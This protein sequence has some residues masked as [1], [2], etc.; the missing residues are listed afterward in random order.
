MHTQR[1]ARNG[2]LRRSVTFVEIDGQHGE[3]LRVRVKV[4]RGTADRL[5]QEAVRSNEHPM[6]YLCDLFDEALEDHLATLAMLALPAADYAPPDPD[7][8]V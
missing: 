3:F 1:T 6:V 4:S 8:G 7:V 5:M 2:G